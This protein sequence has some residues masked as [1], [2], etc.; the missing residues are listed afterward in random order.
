MSIT[1]YHQC[2][3]L[4]KLKIELEDWQYNIATRKVDESK[5]YV[6]YEGSLCKNIE[7]IDDLIKNLKVAKKKGFNLVN[8]SEDGL[9]I[10]RIETEDELKI[11]T[12]VQKIKREN[13]L[14]IIKEGK[15]MLE[16]HYRQK[17]FKS[18]QKNKTSISM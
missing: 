12:E 1:I 17:Y 9:E 18:S 15:E 4:I 2:D 7:N 11:R 10:Y 6:Y 16:W 14:D 5:S 8:N 3:S 13:Y